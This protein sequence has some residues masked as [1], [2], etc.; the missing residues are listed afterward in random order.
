MCWL[1][2]TAL[3]ACACSPDIHESVQ[4]GPRGQRWSSVAESRAFL[5]RQSRPAVIGGRSRP[6]AANDKADSTSRK[7]SFSLPGTWPRWVAKLRQA[8]A[9]EIWLDGARQQP[10]ATTPWWWI[11][12][13]CPQLQGSGLSGDF[14]MPN[15]FRTA[16]RWSG[17]EQAGG[18]RRIR[19]ALGPRRPWPWRGWFGSW[20]SIPDPRAGLSDG[21]TWCPLH[22]SEARWSSCWRS[23][24][25]SSRALAPST[26]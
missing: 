9:P 8:G 1:S 11:S 20:R 26:L 5:C 19:G 15:P 12:A 25:R 24:R 21:P 16:A 6:P 4:A 22:R 3:L 13:A 14:L 2:E 23:G 7:V 18:Q 10:L 17:H